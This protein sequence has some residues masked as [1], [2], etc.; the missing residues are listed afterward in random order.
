MAESNSLAGLRTFSRFLA[1]HFSRSPCAHWA[2]A[3]VSWWLGSLAALWFAVP[4]WCDSRWKSSAQSAICACCPK[5]WGK[6]K[7]CEM[8]A[9]QCGG[10]SCSWMINTVLCFER[11]KWKMWKTDQSVI[12][13]AMATVVM[14][15]QPLAT[16]ATPQGPILRLTSLQVDSIDLGKLLRKCSGGGRFEP[17]FASSDC[18]VISVKKKHSPD[19]EKL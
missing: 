4:P 5:M 3:C 7:R 1:Q 18:S 17:D 14:P 6:S 9:R 12:R 16:Y 15:D 10:N 13:T 19:W 2:M 11:V 8:F